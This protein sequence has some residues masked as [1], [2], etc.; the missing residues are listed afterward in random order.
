MLQTHASVSLA[1]VERC[2]RIRTDLKKRHAKAILESC[3]KGAADGV[4]GPDPDS[5]FHHWL[6]NNTA[7]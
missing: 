1:I 6:C 3:G 4:V 2:L 5:L 7:Q